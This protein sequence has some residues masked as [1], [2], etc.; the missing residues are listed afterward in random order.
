[1][2]RRAAVR[3]IEG[4][5]PSL[6]TMIGQMLMVG[7]VGNDLSDP[8]TRRVL[9]HIEA[10]RLGGVILFRRN[11]KGAAAV[12]RMTAAFRAASPGLPVLVAIDQEG[13]R[14]QRLTGAVGFADTPSA[15]RVADRGER[16][17]RGLY[18]RMAEGLADWGFNVNLAPVVDLAVRADNP[19]ITRVGRAYSA[20]PARVAGLA[21]A[22][23]D[24][25]RE[26]GILTSLKH[27][28]GHGSSGGDTHHGF[29]DVSGSW[30]PRELA[31]FRDMIDAGRADMVM[32]A[33]VHHSDFAPPGSRLPATL[34]P[35]VIEGL[36]RR[37][38]GF[39]G[40]VISDDME[41]GAISALGSPVDVAAKAILAGND[42]LIYAGGAAPGQDLVSVLQSRLRR[43]AL[44][45]PRVAERIRESH[46][47]IVRMKERLGR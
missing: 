42:I 43:A 44:E 9:S 46:A 47:R 39:G 29:V 25:H 41:M 32:V 7:F 22:F 12:K 45:D 14:V 13:G 27:F 19:I 28:P 6:E 34:S 5:G 37:D 40:V 26:A 21:T 8:G 36:L 35:Q 33:H 4:D 23:V 38:L 18:R 24:A 16:A 31:P 17:A 3:A 1:M 11:V 20:D 10:G 2:K 15:A 30:T